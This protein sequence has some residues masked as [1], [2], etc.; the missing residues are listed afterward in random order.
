MKGPQRAP[1]VLYKSAGE[2][3]GRTL[4][5]PAASDRGLAYPCRPFVPVSGR[6]GARNRRD[7]R[8]WH[9]SDGQYDRLSQAALFA[10][11]VGL[12]F[13]RLTTVHWDK[14]RVADP[15]AST[16]KLLKALGK[17]LRRHGFAF[18]YLWVRENGS[19]KGEHVHIL[20]HGP[21]CLPDLN[22]WLARALKSCGAVRRKGVRDTRAVGRRVSDAITRGADY[23]QNVEAGLDYLCKGA[24]RELLFSLH[25]RSEFSGEIVGQRCGVSR[26]VALTERRSGA[27]G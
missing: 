11:A 19:D 18:A 8:S 10:E 17:A 12:P 15:L 21:D 9:L 14:A 25:R 1:P 27:R 26:N 2:C 5:V 16:R 23:L 6:G 22:R 4:G 7:R 20:W 13:N 3:P 24:R